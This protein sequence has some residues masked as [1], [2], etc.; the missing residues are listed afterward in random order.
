MR[1]Y[2]LEVSQRITRMLAQLLGFAQFHRVVPD[3]AAKDNDT[4]QI[5]TGV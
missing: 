5:P 3:M 2:D 1:K 4:F